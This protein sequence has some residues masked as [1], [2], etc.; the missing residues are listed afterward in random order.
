MSRY[1]WAA[2][3]D[4]N[5]FF[6]L[7]LDNIANLVLLVSNLP[8]ACGVLSDPSATSAVQS[9]V[10][11]KMLP[12]TA[13]GVLVGDLVFF[14]LAFRLAKQTDNP[15]VTAMPLGLDTPSLFGMIF[16]VLGPAFRVAI[17]RGDSVDEAINYMW[18]IGMCSIV[19]SG[20]FKLVCSLIS[21]HVHRH[22]PR[23]GLLGSLAAIALVLISFIPAHEV[24][25]TPVV[26]FVALAVILATLTARIRLPYKMPGALGALLVSGAVYYLMLG[27]GT[28]GYEPHPT[29]TAE[30]QLLLPSFATPWWEV[31]TDSLTYL[32]IVLPFAL[33][34][35]VGGIDCT[36]SAAAAG[37]RFAT[38]QVIA[39]EGAATVLA[40]LCGGV[41]QTTPY[42]GHPAYKAM[43]GRAAYTLATAIFVGGAGLLGYFGYLYQWIPHAA[44]YPILIFV[45]L[46]ITSQSYHATNPRHFPAVAVA[47]I[48]ALAYL[49][50]IYA[51]QLLGLTGKTIDDVWRINHQF[52][53]HLQTLR[54]LSGGGSFILTSLLWGSA[55]AMLIDHRLFSA[56]ACFAICGVCSLFGVIHSPLAGGRLVIPTRLPEDLSEA[57]AGMQPIYVAGAYLVVAALLI[58][59][60]FFLPPPEVPASEPVHD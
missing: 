22:L 36:E 31:Y 24:V 26:G 54:M 55:L 1:R 3:G 12:G 7:S 23:A 10:I 57:A 46:E 47:C 11:L 17:D 5:A 4:V 32:P 21:S 45:G 9:A 28:L 58:A 44:I 14:F 42:I 60:Q 8:V 52:G 30:L 49:V 6:G 51:D 35:V 25:R 18:M 2:P 13:L 27:T 53:E 43:G 39:V 59:W 48:P 33:A 41:I 20:V 40:G 19:T 56:A 29:P 50:M 34:T 38:G 15:E 37:D 16:F